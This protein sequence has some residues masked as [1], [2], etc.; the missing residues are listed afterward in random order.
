M[1][2]KIRLY[3]IYHISACGENKFGWDCE[4]ECGVS[5]GITSCSGSLF[6]MPDPVGCTCM[7]GWMGAECNEGKV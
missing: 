5:H 3:E 6:C 7:T 4:H 1:G 2:K